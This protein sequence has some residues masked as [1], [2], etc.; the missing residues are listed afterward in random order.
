MLIVHQMSKV[1]SRSW[2]Q[3]AA[4]ALQNDTQPFHGHYIVPSNLER[5]TAILSG[6]CARITIA[7]MLFANNMLRVGAAAWAQLEAARRRHE[8]VRVI[9]GIR[10]PVARSISLL[11]F[12]AD[13]YGH[14]SR[15][16][17]PRIPMS[18]DYVIDSLRETWRLVLEHREPDDSFG[19]LLWYF[20]GA[21][22]KW[23]SEELGAA[24][25][26][27]VLEGRFN[28]DLGCQRITAMDADVFVYRVEDM[29]IGAKSYAP[30]L[31]QATS[32]LGVPIQEFPSVN[33]SST[34]RTGAVSEDVRR[35]FSLPTDF[36]DT[37]YDEPIVRHFYSAEEITSFKMRWSN[38]RQHR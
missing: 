18:S 32:F 34:R 37:I 10:D 3:A 5:L 38:S 9:T 8:A 36:L 26:I 31:T 16:L 29:Q 35:R 23:F 33:T 20:T 6:Q 17:N 13:F 15:P 22:R 4:A 19:W 27:N 14:I 30:L 25:G 7:N 21:Y 1:A 11:M 2:I 24:Y 28:P 12:L